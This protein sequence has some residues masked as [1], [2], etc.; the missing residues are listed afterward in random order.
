MPRQLD[1]DE[2]SGGLAAVTLVAAVCLVMSLFYLVNSTY[3]EVRKKTW[4]L[5]NTAIS[6]FTAVV[7]YD[8]SNKAFA[9]IFQYTAEDA[10]PTDIPPTPQIVARGISLF[11]WWFFWVFVLYM[12]SGS[13]LRS[14]GFGTIT[15]H[16]MGFAAIGFFGDLVLAQ[17]FRES[18]WWIL[19]L[20]VIEKLTF[21]L[22][23]FCGYLIGKC[24]EGTEDDEEADRYHDTITDAGSDFFSMISAFLASCFLRYLITGQVPSAEG[25]FNKHEAWQQLVLAGFG[26]LFMLASAGF[27]IMHARAVKEKS[28]MSDLM[29]FLTSTWATTSAFCLLFALKWATSV[30]NEIMANLIDATIWTLFGISFIFLMAFVAHHA[31]PAAKVIKGMFTGVALVVGLA[32]E[33]TFDCAM[34]DLGDSLPAANDQAKLAVNLIV[35]I[36]IILMVFPAWVVYILPKADDDIQAAYSIALSQ[37]P[38]PLRSFCCDEDLTNEELEDEMGLMPAT[39]K[40][41]A[42]A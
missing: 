16:I 13:I 11:V 22:L 24:L 37:G 42:M 23:F 41:A 34:D 28:K 31:Q 27:A 20:I 35:I 10:G 3:K 32:W 36:I 29:D 40:T 33:K 12:V 2:S 9:Y 18:A 4:S 17:P 14:K 39:Y 25:Q 30:P 26:F 15:G 38:F 19:L 6:I 21:I 7:L 1:G 8:F 5:I